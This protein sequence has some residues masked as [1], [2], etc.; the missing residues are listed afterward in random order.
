MFQ[1]LEAMVKD[2]ELTFP[3]ELLQPMYLL[4][5]D[6]CAMYLHNHDQMTNMRSMSD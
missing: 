6:L 3:N 2:K 1:Y 5:L 4:Y